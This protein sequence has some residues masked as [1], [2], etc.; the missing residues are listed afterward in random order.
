MM[1]SGGT[2]YGTEGPN[3]EKKPSPDERR[4]SRLILF[5]VVMLMMYLTGHCAAQARYHQTFLSE[6]GFSPD[7]QGHPLAFSSRLQA[8]CY[9]YIAATRRAVTATQTVMPGG[10]IAGSDAEREQFVTDAVERLAQERSEFSRKH[11]IL[12]R[13]LAESVDAFPDI[14]GCRELMTIE[15][16]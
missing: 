15:E 14:V 1:G 16:E 8:L 12:T 2:E 3:T 10:T 7:E 13:Q 11:F 6:F 5:V 9:D 4:H